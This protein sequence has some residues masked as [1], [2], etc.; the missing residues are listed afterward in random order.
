MPDSEYQDNP[1]MQRAIYQLYRDYFNLAERRRRWNLETDIPWDQC[2]ADQ[3]NHAV[4]DIIESFCTV[5]MYLPDY[6]SQILPVVRSSRGRAWFAANWGYEESKHSLAMEDW[7]LK[8]GHRSEEQMHDLENQVVDHPWKIPQGDVRALLTYSMIQE[9]ATWLH[10][11][12]LRNLIGSAGDAAL[13]KLLT[14]IIIDERAHYD[15]FK[16]LVRLHLIEDRAGTLEQLRKVMHDFHMP[17]I[18]LLPDGKRRMELVERLGLFN[19]SIYFEHVYMPTLADLGVERK[20]MRR[21]TRREYVQGA[22]DITPAESA[23]Q[24]DAPPQ[25]PAA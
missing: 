24:A 7:L 10:Y 1:Q 12:N 18:A 15:F 9:H 22:L 20:E 2:Q 17:A 16:K 5:E 3:K 8:S 14:L 21:K 13:F 6:T 19:E 11:R 4:A 25:R 23:T